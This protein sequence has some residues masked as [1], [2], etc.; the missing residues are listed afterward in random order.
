M[1]KGNR[2]WINWIIADYVPFTYCERDYFISTP[3]R[4]DRFLAEQLYIEQYELAINCGL[5]TDNDINKLLV[6]FGYWNDEKEN[7]LNKLIKDIEDIKL[8]IFESY[9]FSDRR[10]HF[11]KALKDTMNYIEKLI[12]E[13]QVFDRYSAR[14]VAEYI[15]HHYLLGC[16]IYKSKNKPL[17]IRPDWFN[18]KDDSIIQYCYKIISDYFL[19]DQDYRRLARSNEWRNICSRKSGNIFGRP[20]VDLSLSQQQLLLWS[21][22][23]D[24]VY[25]N[26]ECPPDE[27]IEDD[28]A[29]DG[30]MIKQRR[31]RSTELNKNSIEN[32]ITNEK[33]LNSDEIYIMCDET[34]IKKVY[35]CNDFQGKVRWNNIMNQVKKEGVVNYMQL[36]DT[37]AEFMRQLA[38]RTI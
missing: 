32:S 15:R 37:Q 21:N 29:L 27:I 34:D 17:F 2:Y 20:L 13:K 5:Y 9:T 14:S 10:R 8:W 12:P 35:D 23:Y 38:E 30:W 19:T 28:D 7:N 6:N 3:S 33:I 11:K 16:S 22:L 31:N 4:K 25:K 26:S 1:F 18:K 36:R 24:N